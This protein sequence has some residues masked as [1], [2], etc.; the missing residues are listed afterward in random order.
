MSAILIDTCSCQKNE[1]L[2]IKKKYSK[3]KKIISH[4]DLLGTFPVVE[5]YSMILKWKLYINLKKN[6]SH[7]SWPKKVTVK[8]LKVIHCY[9]Q[10]GGMHPPSLQKNEMKDLKMYINSFYHNLQWEKKATKSEKCLL[11]NYIP[12]VPSFAIFQSF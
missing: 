10:S 4:I 7:W 3:L 12:T 6:T 9:S 5:M 11:F 8:F 2:K 1:I